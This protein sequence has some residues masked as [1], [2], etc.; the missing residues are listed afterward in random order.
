M[1][2][3][4]HEMTVAVRGAAKHMLTATAAVR[5]QASGTTLDAS[6]DAEADLKA[7]SPYD[8]FQVL[9]AAGTYVLPVL[10]ALPDVGVEPGTRPTFTL[11]VTAQVVEE[12]T[13][14]EAERT[15]AHVD[16]RVIESTC[17]MRLALVADALGALPVRVDSDG[18][19]KAS[20]LGLSD[21]GLTVPDTIEGI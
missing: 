4:E 16:E 12:V 5:A 21:I 3:T 10:V 20:D 8:R 15:G 13:R 7:L 19:L 9:D 1:R 14:A 2:F 18:L 17:A 11:A 6:Y